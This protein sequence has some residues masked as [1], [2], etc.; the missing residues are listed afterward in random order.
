[1]KN[2]KNMFESIEHWNPLEICKNHSSVQQTVCTVL[3]TAGA[4]QGGGWVV[5]SQCE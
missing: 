3:R 5:I 4:G 2:N 1:M